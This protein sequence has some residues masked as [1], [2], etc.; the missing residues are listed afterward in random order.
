M[1]KNGGAGAARAQSLSFT[2]LS[3]LC[4]SVSTL[5]AMEVRIP[6]VP[7]PWT[8]VPTLPALPGVW[9][10]R[11]PGAHGLARG[12]S[13]DRHAR[14]SSPFFPLSFPQQTSGRLSDFDELGRIGE[15]TYGVVLRC[16]HR[17]T[18][19]TVAVKCFK[20]GTE[21]NSVRRAWGMAGLVGRGQFASSPHPWPAPAGKATPRRPPWANDREMG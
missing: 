5:P 12:Q 7:A 19:E 18:G 14:R 1:K 6:L 11:R 21:S 4:V 2:P 16:R 8:D 15:G 17:A 10:A 9:Q 13:T 20:E 3:A